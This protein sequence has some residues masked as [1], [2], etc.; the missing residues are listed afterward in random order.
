MPLR[1]SSLLNN[2]VDWTEAEIT[3]GKKY[4]KWE[5]ATINWENVEL[6]WDEFFILLEVT[7]VLRKGGGGGTSLKEYMEKN[8]WDKTK[9]NIEKELGEEK[10]KKFIKLICKINGIEYKQTKEKQDKIDITTEHLERTFK[11]V[12]KKIGV[13]I[14]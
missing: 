4:V 11:E 10:T 7:E 5:E 14:D 2:T 1:Y 12:S 9:Q 3:E 8:P 13:K 6:T